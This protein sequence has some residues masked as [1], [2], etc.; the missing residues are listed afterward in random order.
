LCTSHE[1]FEHTVRKV[2]PVDLQ[3]LIIIY[4]SPQGYAPEAF[5]V[6]MLILWRNF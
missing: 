5:K 2:D 3:K 4:I 6:S 1:K